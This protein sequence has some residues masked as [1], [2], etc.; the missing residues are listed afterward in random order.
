MAE[1]IRVL[2]VTGSLRIGG[3]ETVAVNLYRFCD[4]SKYAF[5]YVVYGDTVEPLEA[6]VEELGARVFHIPY[7]HKGAGAYLKALKRIM[8]DYGPY[9][10]VHSHSLFNSG[11]VVKAAKE[12]NIPV[13]ISH[14]H[15]D[16]RNTKVS[17]PRRL[18]NEAMRI[19]INRYTTQKVAC[20]EGAGKYL[21][22]KKYDDSVYIIRN[23][24]HVD[25]FQYDP[26]KGR[27]IKA[28][29]GWEQN[30]LVGHIGRL[31]PVKNQK[32]IVQVFAKAYQQD[33]SLRLLIAGD[34]ELKEE[35]QAE[36]DRLGLT[37]VA[38]LAGTRTDVAQ[39]LS[40]FDVYMMA[41][42]YEGVSIS[43]IEAQ[44][45][46]VHCLVSASAATPATRVTSCLNLLELSD[47]DEIWAEKLLQL[48]YQ[49]RATGS[50][51]KVK[52]SGYDIVQIVQ[53]ACRLYGGELC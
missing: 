38:V 18:Y 11:F 35:L 6:V 46:G 53:N 4:R 47:S 13:R 40:A 10:V 3:L 19:L 50:G 45:S 29:F 2:Q 33:R 36:I 37:E 30:K 51:E 31:S 41:S 21:F 49:D 39:L 14:G 12:M 17:L 8:A 20:S 7:P 22:G 28:E 32:R 16:R 43:L 23:G 34:G 44:S 27:K 15:S 26:D 52:E 24:V 42:H 48:A 1:K 25:S 9:D 5:D